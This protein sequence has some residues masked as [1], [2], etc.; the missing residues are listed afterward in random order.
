MTRITKEGKGFYSLRTEDFYFESLLLWLID[1]ISQL[2]VLD[3]NLFLS[4]VKS[5]H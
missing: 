1:V 4:G 3:H 5:G 2:L